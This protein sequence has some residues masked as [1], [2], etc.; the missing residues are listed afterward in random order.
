VEM[1]RNPLGLAELH[2]PPIVL[3]G[4]HTSTFR[5]GQRLIQSACSQ[6]PE[7]GVFHVNGIQVLFDEFGF[8][9]G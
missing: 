4:I 6:E 7:V 2:N 3:A 8:C 5:D 1:H 9:H